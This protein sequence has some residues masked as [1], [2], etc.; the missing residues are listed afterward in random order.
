MF[1]LPIETLPWGCQANSVCGSKQLECIDT[2][3]QSTVSPIVELLTCGIQ[4]A[5]CGKGCMPIGGS[6][7]PSE[8]GFCGLNSYCAVIPET[9]NEGCYLN[10]TT[11][12]APG[13]NILTSQTPQ[14]IVTTDSNPNIALILGLSF[15]AIIG[16]LRVLVAFLS[17]LIIQSRRRKQ[18]KRSSNKP[19][20]EQFQ[21]P[22]NS[23]S[24]GL[25]D[26]RYS[27]PTDIFPIYANSPGNSFRAP[28]API[29]VSR[30]IETSFNTI[31][32]H[33]H[34]VSN[35]SESR[36][37]SSLEPVTSS[38]SHM[39]TPAMIPVIPRPD[40]LVNINGYLYSVVGHDNS[41]G[42]VVQPIVMLDPYGSD[43][44]GEDSGWEANEDSIVSSLHG[45]EEH[46]IVNVHK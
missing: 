42:M 10:A 24:R 40:S 45:S 37:S 9:R 2:T 30:S 34:K 38:I 32:T 39:S 19:A 27:F 26:N 13:L 18:I 44:T 6:C 22:I 17:F 5:P 31:R 7:C 15:V 20:I 3:V 21:S 46:I 8:K 4:L 14:T 43:V 25:P 35:I 12:T 1:K 28:P 11:A 36:T 16:E 23:M 29:Q 33:A 41:G